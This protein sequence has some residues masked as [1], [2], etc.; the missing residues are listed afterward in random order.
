MGTDSRERDVND[1]TGKL[2][3]TVANA[4]KF[5]KGVLNAGRGRG[6]D[7]VVSPETMAS[8]SA[9]TINVEDRAAKAMRLASA[10]Y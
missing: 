1:N 10:G 2:S 3:S 9:Q 4:R 5:A 7:Q 8:M 6:N